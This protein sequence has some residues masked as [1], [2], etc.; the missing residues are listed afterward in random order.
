MTDGLYRL[1][2]YSRNALPDAADVVEEVGRIIEVSRENNARA[3]ITGALLYTEGCFAQILE[4]DYQA[5]ERAFEAIQN[6][7]RHTAVVPLQ[8]ERIAE[9][10]FGLWSMAYVG[11]QQDGPADVLGRTAP[12]PFDPANCSG[13]ELFGILRD[14]LRE[15]ERGVA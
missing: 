6:D 5:I 3:G 7:E 13:A 4:G 10:G 12:A 14:V 1:A 8:F 9:R 11:T 15:Q 2:Y